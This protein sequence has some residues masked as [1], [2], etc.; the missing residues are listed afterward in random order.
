[1]SQERGEEKSTGLKT[2]HYKVARSIVPLRQRVPLAAL[3]TLLPGERGEEKRTGLKT[4]HYTVARCIALLRQGA[5]LVAVL[6]VLLAGPVARGQSAKPAEA[7]ALEQQGKLEEAAAVWRAVTAQNPRDAG[8]FASLGVVL[9]KEQKYPEAAAAYKKALALDRKLPGVELNLGLAEFKQG[10]FEAAIAPFRAALVAQ[11]QNAQARALL[12]LSWYGAK[13]FAEA[14]KQLKV[15]AKSDPGNT[16]LR[17][18]LAQSCL[19]AKEYECALE[20]FRQILQ[21]DPDAA[22]THIL[23]GE[24]LDGLSR[25]PEAIAEFQTAAKAAPREPEVNFGLGYLYWKSH[26]YENAK[27]A[28]ESELAVDANHAQSLA[29]LGDIEL[30]ANH[31]EEALALLN[32]AVKLKDDIRIAYLDLGTILMQ[33]KQNKEALAALL[34]AEK[35]GPEQP[36]AHYRLAR[37]YREMGNAA[38]SQKEFERVRALHEKTE[39]DVGSKMAAPAPSLPPSS[40]N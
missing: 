30:K 8:A 4:R 28:F 3:I 23:M 27:I 17:R 19:L 10:N 34:R 35:L 37:L 15:A 39:G 33:Q 29:Y 18:A 36:E 21:Q 24:A 22:A 20:E 38:A 14:A 12:G 26:Q 6:V 5:R 11:P 16:E 40:P 2:R 25:T 7:I 9:S 1:M 31:P 13:R 32:Q